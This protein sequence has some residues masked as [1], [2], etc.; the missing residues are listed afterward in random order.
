MGSD[1]EGRSWLK[2]LLGWLL[3]AG[4]GAGTV[5]M[6]FLS[7]PPVAAPATERR[8]PAAPTGL[9]CLGFADV[10]SGIIPL[11][12]SQ[13]GRVALVGVHENDNVK[14]G[15]PLVLLDTLAAKATVDEATA[16]LELAKLRVEQAKSGRGRHAVMLEAQKAAL[17]AMVARR[18]ASQKLAEGQRQLRSFDRVSAIEVDAANERVKELDAGVRA[19]EA[20]LREVSSQDP[21]LEM[22]LAQQQETQAA[23]RLQ[24]AKILEQSL[25]LTAPSAGQVL[26]IAAAPGALV[27]P[28]SGPCVLFAPKGPMIVRASVEQEFAS[29]VT[30]RAVA[31]ASDPA[32]PS[33]LWRGKVTRIAAWFGPRR[34]LPGEAPAM[35]DS[36]TLECI[37]QLDDSPNPPRVG[38]KLDVLIRA[39][40]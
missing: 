17:A 21:D 18:G 3:A 36:R 14:A 29:R 25:T 24:Q 28:Q 7:R 27:S 30:E 20:R 31:E 37:I 23:A 26:R 2:R 5:A 11:S 32:N 9:L 1:N 39:G 4:L 34:G 38:Q 15:H 8:V 16:A 13:P 22:R 10:E 12:V 35:N 19:E 40:S 33:H 6:V